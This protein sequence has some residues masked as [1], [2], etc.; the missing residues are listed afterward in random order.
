MLFVFDW[1]GTL[2]DSATKIVACMQQAALDMRLNALEPHLIKNIIGLGLP[3]AIQTLYPLLEMNGVLEY[4]QRYSDH[5]VAA[6]QILCPLF[7][8]AF[9]TLDE[10]K[11]QG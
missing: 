3:E 2:I 7:P 4:K 9:E 5:F 8:G 6:D 1:D 10:L 11:A